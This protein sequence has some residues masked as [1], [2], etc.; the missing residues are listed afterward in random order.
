MGRRSRGRA[1]V[2]GF[3]LPQP[4]GGVRSPGLRVSN[5]GT[6]RRPAQR[7]SGLHSSLPGHSSSPSSPASTLLL[8][9]SQEVRQHGDRPLHYSYLR[10]SRNQ[11]E[12]C[13]KSSGG[14]NHTHSPSRDRRVMW[15]LS[16]DAQQRRPA[17][18]MVKPSFKSKDIFLPEQEEMLFKDNKC[19]H[20]SHCILN[21]N[22]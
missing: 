9:E 12:R 21:R 15:N 4:V 3:L 11:R 14:G 7:C 22:D 19:Y 6:R 5:P 18:K 2:P 8:P 13:S 10:S 1:G 20:L 16:R 17:G